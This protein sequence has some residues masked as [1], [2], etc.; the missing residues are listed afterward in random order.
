MK[1]KVNKCPRQ[2]SALHLA[3]SQQPSAP[4]S[5]LLGPEIPQTSYVTLAKP[6]PAWMTERGRKS[7]VSSLS[8]RPTPRPPGCQ[9][10]EWAG[11]SLREAVERPSHSGNQ[12]RVGDS[13]EDESRKQGD[14][15]RC[16]P[17]QAACPECADGVGSC[18]LSAKAPPPTLNKSSVCTGD[19]RALP[20]CLGPGP[21]LRCINKA[22][23]ADY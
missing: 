7:Q 13:P 17:S 23:A 14:L 20:S 10:H 4:S 21:Y 18:L 6:P 11:R 8:A 15:G 9:Q 5:T 2:G 16:S 12:R 1:L 3:L 22:G 19:Q